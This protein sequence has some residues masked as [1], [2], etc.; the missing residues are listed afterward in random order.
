M[1]HDEVDIERAKRVLEGAGYK[2]SR[3][4]V[5][6]RVNVAVSGRSAKQNAEIYSVF[7]GTVSDLDLDDDE[8]A[9]VCVVFDGHLNNDYLWVAHAD[10]T[11]IQED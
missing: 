7:Q 5:G 2:V 1:C 11:V 4:A 3:L 9:A 6:D 8:D 10:V